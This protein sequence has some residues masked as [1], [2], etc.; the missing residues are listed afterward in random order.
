MLLRHQ[1]GMSLVTAGQRSGLYPSSLLL[2]DLMNTARHGRAR[3]GTTRRAERSIACL[4]S[5]AMIRYHN[6]NYW[7]RQKGL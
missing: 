5:K 4:P 7:N 3:Y 6:A 2:H 1:H